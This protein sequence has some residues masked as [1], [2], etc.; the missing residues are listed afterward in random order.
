MEG[1]QEGQVSAALS[2]LNGSQPS[3]D[4]HLLTPTHA[5]RALRSGSLGEGKGRLK[6]PSPKS[7]A[8]VVGRV[9]EVISLIE[10]PDLVVQ[11]PPQLNGAAVTAIN[12]GARLGLLGKAIAVPTARAKRTA[13][14]DALRDIVAIV[15]ADGVELD[16]G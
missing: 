10:L 14:Q 4:T 1:A 15:R 16:R 3:L 12:V 9:S 5:R 2:T 7:V 11:A 6:A 13:L 8:D